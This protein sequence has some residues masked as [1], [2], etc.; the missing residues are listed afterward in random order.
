[1]IVILSPSKTLDYASL[2]PT[3]AHAIPMFLTESKQ[4][5]ECLCNKSPE[6]I[7]KLMAL[8]DKLAQLN[9]QR[10]RDFHTPFTQQNSRPAILAFKGDVYEG[11]EVADYK[12]ADFAFAQAHLR[13]ISGLYGLLKPLDLIQPYRLEMGTRLKNPRGKDLYEFWGDKITQAI[14]FA[15]CEQSSQLLVNLASQEYFKAVQLAK[16]NGKLLN[17]IF[18]EQQGNNLKIIG[19]FA[20]QARGKMAN[21]IIKNRIKAT[22]ELTNF[23]EDGYKFNSEFSD[24]NNYVFTRNKN[25]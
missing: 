9:A 16:L 23:S 1:M 18:K 25:S 3:Q 20:K 14:N 17:I 6:E 5:I 15:M 7:A 21:F 8:S 11:I 13:I 19:L 10:Y 22:Q 2:L 12:E 4:L 24:G